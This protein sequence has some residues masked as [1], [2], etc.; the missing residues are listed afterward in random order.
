MAL[1]EINNVTPAGT[2]QE[3]IS[4]GRLDPSDDVFDLGFDF[5]ADVSMTLGPRV[6]MIPSVR[7]FVFARDLMQLAF[8]INFDQVQK[9]QMQA[10]YPVNI[11]LT[12]TTVEGKIGLR[13][14]IGSDSEVSLDGQEY[15]RGEEVAFEL[16]VLEFNRTCSALFKV[17][18]ETLDDIYEGV[19]GV[20]EF[21]GDIY[22]ARMFPEAWQLEH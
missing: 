21:F 7:F 14:D 18:L 3:M 8:D 10:L 17:A 6:V 19:D 2:I 5:T 22:F 1:A 12:A 20:A 16:G 9:L 13:F 4:D 11:I 15:R